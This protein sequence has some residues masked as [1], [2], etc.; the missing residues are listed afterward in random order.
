MYAALIAFIAICVF[1]ASAGCARPQC[2]ERAESVLSDYALWQCEEEA[3]SSY[4]LARRLLVDPKDTRRWNASSQ[5]E[6]SIA[7]A[8]ARH[9]GEYRMPLPVENVPKISA[10]LTQMFASRDEAAMCGL[11]AGDPSGSLVVGYAWWFGDDTCPYEGEYQ[12]LRRDG[13]PLGEGRRFCATWP[14]DCSGFVQSEDI[15]CYFVERDPPDHFD[16]HQVAYFG[17]DHRVVA[18]TR[19]GVWREVPHLKAVTVL[20]SP[21]GKQVAAWTANG[22]G[23]RELRAYSADL[24]TCYWTA[25]IESDAERRLDRNPTLLWSFDGRLLCA[26]FDNVIPIPPHDWRERA[27]L[28]CWDAATGALLKDAMMPFCRLVGGPVA[29]MG[30]DDV[31][32]VCEAFGLVLDTPEGVRQSITAA[33]RPTE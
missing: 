10:W 9:N 4:V 31:V 24:R 25:A 20:A 27:V 26:C 22:E 21:D 3:P 11:S 2:V 18:L 13:R 15:F 5:E 28:F 12:L 8:C 16:P 14:G 7:A 30:A 1:G 32:A 23:L 29:I 6:L 33:S 17:T 19:A